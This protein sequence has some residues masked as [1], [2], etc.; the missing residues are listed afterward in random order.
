MKRSV[1]TT[2]L[3]FV[4][5]LLSGCEFNV[6]GT[7]NSSKDSNEY[8]EEPLSETVEKYAAALETS[9]QFVESFGSGDAKRSWSL[10]HSRLREIVSEDGIAGM[11]H[12]TEMDFGSF[13]EYKPM[14]WGFSTNSKLANTVVSIKI[15]VHE[16]TQVFYILNF[17]DDGQYQTILGFNIV[18]RKDNESIATAAGQ[19]HGLN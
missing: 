12:R 8:F 14:Q 3:I 5:A 18:Q 13:V 7:Y 19:A 4:S 9:N 17:E 1:L 15:V 11:Q 16:K 2:A 6:S 10:L